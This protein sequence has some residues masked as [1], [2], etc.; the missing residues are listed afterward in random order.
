MSEMVRLIGA[1]AFVLLGAASASAQPTALEY[2]GTWEGT[3]RAAQGITRVVVVLEPADHRT[4]RG[5]FIFFADNSNRPVP[6]GHYTIT[7]SVDSAGVLSFDGV[8]WV[9]RPAPYIFAGFAGSLSP[10]LMTWSGKVMV[11][12]QGITGEFSVRRLTGIELYTG[13]KAMTGQR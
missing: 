1:T 5:H 9:I 7:G 2:G 4:V 10:G 11:E 3:Y 8:E 6:S 13:P 12:G